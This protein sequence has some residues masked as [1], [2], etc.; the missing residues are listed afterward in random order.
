MAATRFFDFSIPT[1]YSTPNTLGGLSRTVTDLPPGGVTIT[2][3][4]R[5]KRENF[6]SR[7]GDVAKFERTLLELH[8]MNFPEISTIVR[9]PMWLSNAVKKSKICRQI[10]D[11]L[12]A[13][14]SHVG[15]LTMLKI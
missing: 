10:F 6:L 2:P 11:F 13:F 12:T 9:Q 5:P 7:D 1:S 3:L 8:E 14:D 15:A 4:L